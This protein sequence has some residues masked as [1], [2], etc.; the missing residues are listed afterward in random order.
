MLVKIEGANNQVCMA[1]AFNISAGRLPGTTDVI[2]ANHVGNNGD[3][4][5]RTAVLPVELDHVFKQVA[6]DLKNNLVPDFTTEGVQELREKNRL[7]G[8]YNNPMPAIVNR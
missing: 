5:V 1:E 4:A 3:V 7:S 6:Y 2:Y 8:R